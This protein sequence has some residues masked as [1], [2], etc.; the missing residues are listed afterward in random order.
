MNHD[1]DHALED[2]VTEIGVPTTAAPVAAAGDGAM[3][4]HVRAD[5]D[6]LPPGA[7][8]LPTRARE[9][10]VEG[11]VAE[12]EEWM[13]EAIE[14]LM[15]ASPDPLFAT[16]VRDILSAELVADEKP[17]LSLATVRRAFEILL[18]RWSNPE[19]THARSF[20]LVELEGALCFRTAATNARWIRRMQT[21]RPQK[22]SR[23]AL[24]T[25][26][27]IAYRQP[28]TKPQVEDVRGVDSGAALKALLDRKLIRVLGK[29]DDVGRPLLYGT[30]RQFLDFFGLKNLNELPTLK[31]LHE[32]ENGGASSVASPTTDGVRDER[33]IVKDLWDPKGSHVVSDETERESMDALDALERALGQ[34]KKVAK[35]A[36]QLV[37]GVDDVDDERA[38]RKKDDE[39]PAA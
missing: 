29:A 8:E 12:I 20:R 31:Q 27:V 24:E 36:S 26:A 39:D 22:L 7:D 33:S 6:A 13:L 34:A 9:R 18:E 10:V 16:R 5:S 30:T 14:A 1:D 2:N 25:L 17:E 15:F 4:D 28:A 35:N 21:G 3:A 32:I 38:A 11:V 19:R 23:A 37:F